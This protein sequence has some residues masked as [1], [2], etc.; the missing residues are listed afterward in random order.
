MAG[1]TVGVLGALED[2][3]TGLPQEIKV[4]AMTIVLPSQ[5][6]RIAGLSSRRMHQ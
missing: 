2:K 6:W 1:T 4:G 3:F 5:N